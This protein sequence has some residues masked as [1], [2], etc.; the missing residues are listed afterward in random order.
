VHSFC[1]SFC[2]F[3]LCGFFRVFFSCRGGNPATQAPAPLQEEGARRLSSLF[4]VRR[5]I[6]V[7]QLQ[8]RASALAIGRRFRPAVLIITFTTLLALRRG[9][10]GA[11]PLARFD[12][13]PFA[14]LV[15][16]QRNVLHHEAVDAKVDEALSTQREMQQ[17][18]QALVRVIGRYFRVAHLPLELAHEEALGPH[19]GGV[20]P[21][22]LV[23]PCDSTVDKHK[24]Q[25][26]VERN[27]ETYGTDVS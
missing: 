24:A 13:K 6:R 17:E 4:L 10:L 19:G 12:S 16:P 1:L 21:F 3:F 5:R 27:D 25:H 2:N 11:N 18:P 8:F 14:E 23:R 26:Q 9:P 15:E 7:R 22:K 20:C